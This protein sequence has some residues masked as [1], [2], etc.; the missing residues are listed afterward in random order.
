[1]NDNTLSNAELERCA[2]NAIQWLLAQPATGKRSKAQ[3]D[4][5]LQAERAW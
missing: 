1:M 3:I 4:A 2:L 5:D